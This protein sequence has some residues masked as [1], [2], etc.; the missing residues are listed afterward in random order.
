MPSRTDDKPSLAPDPLGDPPAELVPLSDKDI[1]A[2]I[3]AQAKGASD[4][5][6]Q[7]V[8]EMLSSKSV[9]EL[10]AG[11]EN[12]AALV[13]T[14]FALLS[15]KWGRSTFGD[16]KGVFAIMKVKDVTGRER[17]VT[18]GSLNI[19]TALLWFQQNEEKPPPLTIRHSE[20]SNGFDVY[21]FAIAA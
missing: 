21:R 20:T 1:A 8:G 10:L 13:D 12:T 9:E 7:I 14:T 4:V 16:K 18:S 19:M 6:L 3:K 11:S 2:S 17:V 5:S 15:W